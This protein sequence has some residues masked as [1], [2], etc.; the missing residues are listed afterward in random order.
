MADD[1]DMWRAA[2]ADVAPLGGKAKA[3]KKPQTLAEKTEGREVDTLHAG[4]PA[5][6]QGNYPPAPAHVQ[7]APFGYPLSSATRPREDP[8]TI[9]RNEADCLAGHIATID[10]A[11]RKKLA[12]G[13]IPF[14][15]RMD[16]HGY[17]EGDAWLATM[18]FLHECAAH[19]HRCALLIHGKGRG[20]GV[21]GDMGVIKAQMASWLAHH[22]KVM[23]FHTAVP[24]DGGAGAVYVYLKRNRQA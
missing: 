5:G 15:A 21:A 22:P 2:M 11:T 10:D 1:D 17:L 23:A 16:L 12:K 18:D 13:E 19:G 6:T 4:H 14:T 3:H 24:R 7:E 9:L 20:W 8:L